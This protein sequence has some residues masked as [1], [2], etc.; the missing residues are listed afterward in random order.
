[1]L[2]RER[3]SEFRARVRAVPNERSLGREFAV[4]D[5]YMTTM[6]IYTSKAFLLIERN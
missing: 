5:I 2:A 3:V 6:T 4:H 1:M